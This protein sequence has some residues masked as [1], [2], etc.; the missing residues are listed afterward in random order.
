VVAY[1]SNGELNVD[2]KYGMI[3]VHSSVR[4]K[5]KVPYEPNYQV[6]KIQ[7]I[8]LSNVITDYLKS[9]GVWQTAQG[10]LKENIFDKSRK[11]SYFKLK[12]AQI[13]ISYCV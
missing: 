9:Q 8:G 3:T 7:P 10:L 1:A 12:L 4:T 2:I 13:M 11:S 6:M 5:S